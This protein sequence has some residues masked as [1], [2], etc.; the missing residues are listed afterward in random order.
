MIRA[1]VSAGHDVR[2]LADE[3]LAPDVTA[4]GAEHIAWT[5][6][7]QRPGLAPQDA[8]VRDW[9]ARSP[10]QAFAAPARA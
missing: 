9:D 3:V 2:V 1:L 4:T 7:P 8:V 5:T 6:A 10:L